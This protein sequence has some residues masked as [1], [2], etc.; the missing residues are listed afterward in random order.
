MVLLFIVL[1]LL[2]YSDYSDCYSIDSDWLLTL[3]DYWHCIK[4][5]DC[6]PFWLLFPA[7]DYLSIVI[8]VLFIIDIPIR[9]H[10]VFITITTHLLFDIILP[11]FNWPVPLLLYC[12]LYYYWYWYSMTFSIRYWPH[13]LLIFCYCDPLMT[14]S[15][16]LVEVFGIGPHSGILMIHY[17]YS[18][19]CWWYW[20][21][22][23]IDVTFGNYCQYWHCSIVIP[24]IDDRYY[25]HWR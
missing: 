21:W 16:F 20:Y 24:S 7:G 13:L 11:L 1:L 18:S 22:W 4:V 15:V 9:Y 10:S 6:I 25:I 23:P 17:C 12:Y 14:H 5:L 3:I 19:D 8:P 2:F